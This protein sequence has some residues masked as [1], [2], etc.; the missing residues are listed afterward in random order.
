MRPDLLGEALEAYQKVLPKLTALRLCHR[1]GKVPDVHVTKLPLELLQSIEGII[2]E[3]KLENWEP[4]SWKEAFEHFEGRCQP[5]DHVYDDRWMDLK[6]DAF[7]GLGDE[8]CEKCQEKGFSLCDCGKDCDFK[9]QGRMNEIVCE[10]G[11]WHFQQCDE[12][13]WEVMIS[14]DNFAPYQK[15]SSQT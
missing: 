2:F 13:G 14:A 10:S 8:M 5:S 6:D 7:D 4:F 15:V 11:R 3:R 12:A 1:F 9:V